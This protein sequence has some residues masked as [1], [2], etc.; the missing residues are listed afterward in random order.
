M[1]RHALRARTRLVRVSTCHK[2]FPAPIFVS[3]VTAETL[4]LI[5][6]CDCIKYIFESKDF[7]RLTDFLLVSSCG[8]PFFRSMYVLVYLRI[9]FR[10]LQP[11]DVGSLRIPFLWIVASSHF[12]LVACVFPFCGSMVVATLSWLRASPFICGFHFCGSTHA[13]VHLRISFLWIDVCSHMKL[14]TCGFPFSWPDACLNSFAV[15]ARSL[16]F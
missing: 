6:I 15:L 14:V 4:F 2:C 5:L 9:P 3:A 8:V 7:P 10:F 12:Q 1:G 11:H 13:L 16:H